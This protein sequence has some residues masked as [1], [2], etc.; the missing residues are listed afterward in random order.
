MEYV[1]QII[2][3][4]KSIY[5]DDYYPKDIPKKQL[6]E[7]L[8]NA[9]LAP[10]HKMTE[11]WRFIVLSGKHKH[12]YGDFMCEFYH[13]KYLHLE[14]EE[15]E[16]KFRYLRN[17]PLKASCMVAVIMQRSKSVQIPEWEEIAAISCAV[18]NMALSCTAMQIGS[19]WASGGS[20]IDYVKTLGLADNEIS[21]GLF[22]MGY[23]HPQHQNKPRRRT[24][25][26]EKVS[27]LE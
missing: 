9:T 3:Q 15:R 26:S 18:Q 22:F 14:P 8:E 25:I 16:A 6:E 13:E 24:P 12:L 10:T 7:I 27:W 4:R 19:Y 11:P 23:F 5:A 17:Y 20:A 2:R 21:L 1:S